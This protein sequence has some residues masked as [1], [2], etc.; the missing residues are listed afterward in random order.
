[1]NCS[2]PGLLNYDGPNYRKNEQKLFFD[3][4]PFLNE[5]TVLV[6]MRACS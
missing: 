3:V 5:G 2:R 4:R 1:L 6:R